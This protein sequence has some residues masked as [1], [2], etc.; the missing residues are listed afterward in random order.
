ME[1]EYTIRSW[2]KWRVVEEWPG[3]KVKE[4]IVNSHSTL[5]YQKHK[6]RAEF[7]VVQSGTGTFVK[8]DRH[9]LVKT[10]NTMLV[11]KNEWHQIVNGNTEP[12]VII[13]T[14]FGEKVLEEDIE[15]K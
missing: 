8:G 12:M 10:G 9:H 3:V 1:N 13:E 2:G 11:M 7:W 5:S 4:V 6:H 15:R 14:Q